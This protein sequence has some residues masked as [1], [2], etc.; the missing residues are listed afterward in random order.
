MELKLE[1]GRYVP[2]GKG[3]ETVSG[4]EEIAQ[5]VV[6][7]LTARRGGFAPLPEYGSRLY[8]L[9]R[10]ALPSHW[11]TAAMHY[12]AESLAEEPNVV[13]T[14]VTVTPLTGD[15]LRVDV[16]FTADGTE[17]TAGVMV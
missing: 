10:T 16:S 12:V 3:L 6:M 5:R 14:D 7:R 2:G 17:F 11:K 15:S 1:Q 9:P 8:L 13:V 4:A